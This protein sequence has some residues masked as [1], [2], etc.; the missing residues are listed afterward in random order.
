MNQP[1]TKVTPEVM[2][3]I[4]DL[5]PSVGSL[6]EL[7]MMLGISSRVVAEHAAPLIAIMRA[8]GALPPCACGRERFHQYGCI[9]GFEVRAGSSVEDAVYLE[10][11]RLVL[12]AIANG[13]S[14]RD[15]ERQL[16]INRRSILRF[17]PLL[18]AEQR[19]RR[20]AINRGHPQTSH[21]RSRRL[22]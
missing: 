20:R 9:R 19:E 2:D 18:S 11:K 5:L 8:Q 6:R 15:I 3:Q 13:T 22:A 7:S 1:N 17:L 10:R 21:L 4:A 12:E 16:G 14:Y